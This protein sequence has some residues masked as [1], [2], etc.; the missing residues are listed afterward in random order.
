MRLYEI[1]FVL[2]DKDAEAELKR[3]IEAHGV[4]IE[5]SHP[6]IDIRLSYPISKQ[7]SGFFGFYQGTMEPSVVH[8]LKEKLGLFPSVLRFL[9]VTPPPRPMNVPQESSAPA[10]A[11]SPKPA[12]QSSPAILSNEALEEKLEE[13]L[14]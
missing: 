1:A 7:M 8:S 6:L 14:K 5:Y 9:I 13:I 12:S 10:R 4:N 2:K 11:E 3:L